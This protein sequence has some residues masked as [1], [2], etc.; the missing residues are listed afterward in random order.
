ML[1]EATN[2]GRRITSLS[3]FSNHPMDVIRIPTLWS[4]DNIEIIDS[5]FTRTGDVSYSYLDMIRIG[6]SE[7]FN[8]KIKPRVDE[9]GEVCTELVA[10]YLTF[11]NTNIP[12]N[13]SPGK[14]IDILNDM[15]NYAV[16]EIIV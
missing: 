15:G 12:R 5:I 13:I 10:D 11:Y 1:L 4:I 9:N 6:I 16:I 7:L 3:S 8:F 2:G 14:Q